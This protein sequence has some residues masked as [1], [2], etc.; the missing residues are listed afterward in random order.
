LD[1]GAR[2]YLS[3]DLLA[4]TVYTGHADSCEDVRAERRLEQFAESLAAEDVSRP[5]VFPNI[6]PNN[7][8]KNPAQSQFTLERVRIQCCFTSTET[9]GIIRNGKPRTATSTFT[10]LLTD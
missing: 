10:Q 4:F 9:V 2:Q 8:A 1:L 7:S 3:G 5:P 6:N